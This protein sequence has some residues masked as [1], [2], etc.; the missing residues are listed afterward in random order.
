MGVANSALDDKSMA[1]AM[2]VPLWMRMPVAAVTAYRLLAAVHDVQASHAPCV[3]V[4][5]RTSPAARLLAMLDGSTAKNS[6]GPSTAFCTKNPGPSAS[7]TGAPPT[8]AF[9]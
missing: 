9:T 4:T 2:L 5:L 7:P 6:A 3:A 8:A 1:G